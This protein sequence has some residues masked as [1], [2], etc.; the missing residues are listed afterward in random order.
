[1]VHVVLGKG[2]LGM[3]LL[4]QLTAEKREA[5]M[6]SRSTGWELINFVEEINKLHA[7]KNTDFTIWNCIGGG[8]VEW[9]DKHKAEAHHSLYE[10]P[11]YLADNLADKI[12]LVH[13]SSDYALEP[14]LSYYAYLKAHAEQ[15]MVDTDKPNT[16]IMRVT[17]LYGEHFP[18]RS[19]PI[20]LMV[21]AKKQGR[22]T[23][24]TNEICPTPTDWL[25]W[26][27][28]EFVD[29][30][31][32]DSTQIVEVKPEGS[33]EVY[34]FGKKVIG[35]S[36][37]KRGS[38]DLKRPPEMNLHEIPTTTSWED[39]WNERAEFYYKYFQLMIQLGKV[40]MN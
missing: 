10:I 6:A 17:S 1:M 24:P 22:L 15:A 25:A 36:L 2:N 14:E 9:A 40:E 5:Y 37:V 19:L 16:I 27:T 39:L 33:C 7:E 8:S 31:I 38:L 20:K 11:T 34:E 21:N 12:R 13:F 3:D 28:P 29:Q 4:N 32:D 30:G 26:L 35:P 18:D 23:L